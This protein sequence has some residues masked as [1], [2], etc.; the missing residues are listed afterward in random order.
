MPTVAKVVVIAVLALLMTFVLPIPMLALSLLAVLLCGAYQFHL[1]SRKLAEDRLGIKVATRR[2]LAFGVVSFVIAWFSITAIRFY[3]KVE[4][5]KKEATVTVSD[6]MRAAEKSLMSGNLDA[7]IKHLKKVESLDKAENLKDAKGLLADC[8]KAQ[9]EE[10]LRTALANMTDEQFAKY[11]SEPTSFAPLFFE[12]KA[13]N[14]AFLKRLREH[15]SDA[16]EIRRGEKKKQEEAQVAKQAAEKAA[17]L[18]RLPEHAQLRETMPPDQLE[19]VK[20]FALHRTSFENTKIKSDQ[21]DFFSSLVTNWGR[22]LT[23]KKR[24]G[25][26]DI[27]PI[28]GWVAVVDRVEEINESY[29]YGLLLI[30]RIRYEKEENSRLFIRSIKDKE[31][32]VSFSSPEALFSI[33]RSNPI[34]PVVS[35]LGSGDR[36]RFDGYFLPRGGDGPYFTDSHKALTGKM[37]EEVGFIFTSVAKF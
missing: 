5:Q 21:F 3:G 8:E 29:G 12:D 33:V 20:A 36:V 9:S 7:A 35:N 16:P 25:I 27:Y 34:F 2:V 26:V 4:R 6:A 24:D 37:P 31:E 22:L 19:F 13:L 28:K 32:L 11:Q 1:P 15:S 17:R 18:S 23:K 30:T 10:F 14:E